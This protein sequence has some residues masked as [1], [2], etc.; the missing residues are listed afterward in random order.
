VA[1]IAAPDPF[2]LERE[3][4]KHFD[5]VRKYGRKKEFFLITKEEIGYHF[6]VRSLQVQRGVGNAS[7]LKKGKKRSST[8]SSPEEKKHSKGQHNSVNPR[9]AYP[10][11]V[12]EFVQNH[13]QL[14]DQGNC[15]CLN[16]KT[17]YSA[18]QASGNADEFTEMNFIHFSLSV[19]KHLKEIFPHVRHTKT[20]QNNE[21]IGVKLNE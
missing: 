18:F 20:N 7:A 11:K 2:A 6:H 8:S 14:A 4:H 17:I 12:K 5:S 15:K 13:V 9:A 3:I 21:Y 19:S 10:M 1:S 16:T